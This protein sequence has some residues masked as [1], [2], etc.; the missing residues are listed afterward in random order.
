MNSKLE[1]INY[2][3]DRARI[4]LSEIVDSYLSTGSPVSSKVIAKNINS[5]LSPSTVRLIMSKLEKNGFLFSPHTSSGRMPTDKG[6]KF[7]VDGILEV[8]DLTN[9]ERESIQAK[10]SVAGKT[11]MEVLDHSSK[12]LSGLSN[13]TSLVFAPNNIDRPLKHIEFVSMDNHRALVITIDING[14]VENRLVEL[15]VGF[16]SSSL[17]EASNYI[18]SKTYG[19]TLSEVKSI[20]DE[21]LKLK[22]SEVEKLSEQLVSAGIAMRSTEKSDPHFLINRRDLFYG[23]I[24]HKEDIKKLDILLN[25][26]QDQKNFVNILKYTLK[27]MG[28]HVFI[29]SNTKIFNLAGCSMIIAP[30]KRTSKTIKPN[31]LGAIGVIGPSRLNYAR[32]IP[33]VDF[34]ARILNK[35]LG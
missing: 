15:P 14:L 2:I 17:I 7:F 19:K 30:L 25:E 28:V 20:I 27:G 29:G 13:C 11:M 6:L 34:T 3:G 23:K 16:T 32:I 31:T 10:C 9:D 5:M 21:E 12:E 26:I 18:N 35:F 1:N 33:M 4:I 8:G 24:E 22:S